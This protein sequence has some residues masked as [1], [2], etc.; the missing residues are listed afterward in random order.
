MIALRPATPGDIPFVM[1][2]ERIP[3]HEAF[4]NQ[5]PEAEHE[6]QLASPAFAYFIGEAQGVPAG[7]V[8]LSELNDTRGNHCIKRIAVAEPG[9]GLGTPLFNAVT[10]W[11]F[12]NTDVHRL[13]LHALSGNPRARHVYAREGFTEEGRLREARPRPAGTRADLVIMSILRPEWSA[14]RGLG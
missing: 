5:Q 14:R 7:F 8:I 12:A 3:G 4:I 6:A 9:R 10:D 11:A 13:W 1:F 2:V